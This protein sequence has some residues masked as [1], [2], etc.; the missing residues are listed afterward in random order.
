MF[1]SHDQNAGKKLKYLGNEIDDVMGYKNLLWDWYYKKGKTGIVPGIHSFIR[2]SNNLNNALQLCTDQQ[3]AHVPFTYQGNS[4]SQGWGLAQAG[5]GFYMTVDLGAPVTFDTIGVCHYDSQTYRQPDN[6]NGYIKD[7]KIEVSD[8]GTNEGSWELVKAQADD[9]RVD[10]L[11]PGIRFFSFPSGSVTKRWVRYY[12]GGGAGG[13]A[14]SYNYMNFFGAY[15][16]HSGSGDYP[17][18]V[19]N[20]IKLKDTRNLNVGDKVWIWPK[21]TGAKT[22]NSDAIN[23]A[24]NYNINYNSLTNGTNGIWSDDGNPLSGS[25]GEAGS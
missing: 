2:S 1:P 6:V 15:M 10:S 7:V 3:S 11:K 5:A 25:A 22:M 20:Q 12:S 21:N 4:I 17:L 8:N 18:P 23:A 16:L 13:A 14:T 19:T 9:I 24:Y